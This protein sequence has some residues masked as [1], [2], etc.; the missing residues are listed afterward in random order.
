MS[1][2]A[3]LYVTLRANTAQFREAMTAAGA[4][5]EATG[6]KLRRNLSTTGLIV[7]ASLIAGGVAAVKMASDF[8]ASMT[9]VNTLAMG[10]KGNINQL[11]NAVLGLAGQV[12]YSPNS[13]AQALYH[14]ES[15]FYS[16]GLGGK[17]ALDA[18]KVAAQ[19]AQIGGA[20]LVDVTNALG[21]AV[22]SGIPG[23]NDY[24]KAMQALLTTVGAGDMTMQNLADAFSNGILAIG[25]QYGLTLR[26]MGAALA[27]L[28]DNNIRGAEAGTYLKM[29]IMDLAVQSKKGAAVLLQYG[30]TAGELGRDLRT[31]GLNKAL[32]DLRTHLTA[33]GITGTKVGA[34]LAQAFTKRSSGPLAVLLGQFDRLQSKYKVITKSADSFGS[35]WSARLHTASQQWDNLKST[36]EAGLIKIGTALL[37]YVIKAMEA[38]NAALTWLGHHKDVL[39]ALAGGA[40]ALVGVGL[41]AWVISL[42]DPFTLI[43]AGIFAVGAGLTYLYEHSKTF[44]TIVS[45]VGA[46]IRNDLGAAFNWLSKNVFPLVKQAWSQVVAYFSQT[47]AQVTQWWKQNSAEIQQVATVVWGFIKDYIA[48]NLAVIV[49]VVKTVWPIIKADFRLA[50]H[51]IENIVSIYLDLITGH[52]H[53]FWGDL[54]RL[55]SQGFSD[56]WNLFTTSMSHLEG[57]LASALITLSKAFLTWQLNLAKDAIQWGIHIVTGLANGIMSGGGKVGDALRSVAGGVIGTAFKVFHL[58]SPSRLFHQFGLWLGQGLA[59]GITASG[60]MVKAAMTK[61]GTLVTDTFTKK[62]RLHQSWVPDHQFITALEKSFTLDFKNFTAA[63]D[64]ISKWSHEKA[65][66]NPADRKEALTALVKLHTE[67]VKVERQIEKARTAIRHDPHAT[68]AERRRI[69]TEFGE[70]LKQLAKANE[71]HT[72]LLNEQVAAHKK[73]LH[74]RK[75]SA[76]KAI[77]GDEVTYLAAAAA[78]GWTT[79]N[80]RVMAPVAAATPPIVVELHTTN[81]FDGRKV[82]T[83]VQRH[84][85]KAERRNT[86][87]GTSARRSSKR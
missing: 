74:V 71:L 30:I 83:E 47:F 38:L 87:N 5:G 60:A 73:A 18:L 80:A 28:G 7:G 52:W 75:E 46:A 36:L 25:K 53:K 48:T 50:L 32:I 78:A 6:A 31:G 15:N 67:L 66:K 8:Q 84:L 62:G 39:Y 10:G 65:H 54:K 57:L 41:V 69:N 19:G 9:R 34:V 79:R 26:D 3:D 86:N 64:S 27:T 72:K 81:T 35:A 59:N 44:R 33:A 45:T 82:T 12:G 55:I 37:P 63:R 29:T 70:V 23:V 16:V 43:V 17:Q 40:A 4:Q 13:L 58:G 68:A 77:A 49:K 21:A 14:I 51:Y 56:A 76:K 85:V 11:S 42:L 2:V 20:D 22:A 61:L 24:Q 1:E